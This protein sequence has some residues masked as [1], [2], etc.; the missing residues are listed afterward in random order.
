VSVSR[1]LGIDPGLNAAGLGV[2][3]RTADDRLIMVAQRTLRPPPD[4]PFAARLTFLHL[5]V[6]EMIEEH[7]PQALAVEEAFAGRN[8][9]SG[10]RLG[11]ARSVCILAGGLA[12]LPVH[13]LPPALVKKA[14]AGHG[15]AGKETVRRAVLALLRHA[16]PTGSEDPTRR[17]P[18]YDASD[19]LALALTALA[20]LDT[21]AE[22][23]PSPELG[24]RGRGRGGRR[25]WTAEE[26]EALIRERME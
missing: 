21:P 8:V 25:R 15:R 10:I 14:I 7:A 19:A 6:V 26:V 3:E 13:E 16:S 5:G 20:R 17:L 12:E 18:S 4:A 11:E 1:V 23:R 9:K 2:V 24:R 22:L